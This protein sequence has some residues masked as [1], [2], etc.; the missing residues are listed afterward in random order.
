MHPRHLAIA[1]FLLSVL[2]FGQNS[3]FG[4]PQTVQSK[5]EAGEAQSHSLEQYVE[6]ASEFS[7]RARA[8]VYFL[9]PQSI[10]VGVQFNFVNTGSGSLTFLRRDMVASGRIPLIAARVY[11]SSSKGTVDFG[12]GWRLSA[13]ETISVTGNKAELTTESGYDVSLVRTPEGVFQ[14]E[15]DYPSD[16]LSLRKT[17]PDTIQVSLRSGLLKEFTRI[18]NN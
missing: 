16:Y 12:S 10:F 1:V 11:D 7:S 18:E 9:N 15:K 2:S 13:T 14:L 4:G 6:R 3:V 5:T 8:N 17:A